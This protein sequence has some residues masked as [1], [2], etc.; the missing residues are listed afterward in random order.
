MSLSSR[1]AIRSLVR[2]ALQTITLGISLL[3]TPAII[4]DALYI[5][6]SKPWLNTIIITSGHHCSIGRLQEFYKHPNPVPASQLA[7]GV[8]YPLCFSFQIATPGVSR[9]A[10]LSLSL[11]VP[12]H[13]LACGGSLPFRERV[14]SISSVFRSSYPPLIVVWSMLLGVL[15]QQMRRIILRQVLAA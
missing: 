8:A 11:W 9:A 6:R 7:P 3:F 13:G 5:F 2:L 14:Q 4:I 1:L 10:S 15:C 12:C